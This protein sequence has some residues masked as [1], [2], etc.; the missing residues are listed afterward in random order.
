MHVHAH[1]NK[2]NEKKN[3]KK[4]HVYAKSRNVLNR[5]SLV[6]V[7]RA[8]MYKDALTQRMPIITKQK[9]TQTV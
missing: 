4:K 9:R 7:S 6:N 1:D 3:Y 5:R 8:N 2:D